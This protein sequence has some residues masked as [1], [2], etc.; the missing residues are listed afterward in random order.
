MAAA[1]R[2][3]PKRRVPTHSP[4]LKRDGSRDWIIS[5]VREI[6]DQLKCVY[7]TC[8]TAQL[9]LQGQSAEQDHEILL[10]LRLHVSEPVSRQ[11][12]RLE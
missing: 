4:R 1:N 12:E 3:A 5:E 10:A 8:V 2:I 11:V 9:A 6:A 7:A